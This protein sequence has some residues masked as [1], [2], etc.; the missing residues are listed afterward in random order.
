M[1]SH[2]STALADDANLFRRFTGFAVAVSTPLL[3]AMLGSAIIRSIAT[4]LSA[5][6]VLSENGSAYILLYTVGNA[7]FY[8]LPILLAYTVAGHLGCNQPLAILA[9]AILVH[10][11]LTELL[12][13]KGSAFFKLPLHDTVYPG[14]VLPILLLIP[15][16]KPI[17]RLA[18][19]LSPG[20]LKGFLK[21][22][23]ILLLSIP[24][25]LW[26][27]GPL[28]DLAGSYLISGFSFLYEHIGKTA[29]PLFSLLTP[30]WV[31]FGITPATTDAGEAAPWNTALL[32]TTAALTGAM[33]AVF[34]RFRDK[35][36]RQT[37]L[38][39]GITALAGIPLP[40]LYGVAL[41]KGM[42]LL[43]V[44]VGSGAGGLCATLAG[45]PSENANG[46]PSM[47]ETAAAL[48]GKLTGHSTLSVL[49]D[50]IPAALSVGIAI[51]L[52]FGLTW[53]F[54][55]TPRAEKKS[56]A[57]PNAAVVAAFNAAT[58]AAFKE[59]FASSPH[60]ERGGEGD[61][62]PRAITFSS[63]LSGKVIPLSQM[64]DP[65]FA[66][67]VMGQGCAILP[68][69]GKIYAPCDGTVAAASDLCN[70]LTIDSSEGAQLFIHVGRNTSRLSGKYFDLCCRAGDAVKEG[71]LLLSFDPDA[72]RR[73][74]FD[75]T[76]PLL[77]I[78]AER[79]DDLSLTCDSKVS[80]GDR[81]LTL[82]PKIEGAK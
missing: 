79:Y 82:T 31:L 15:L 32:S 61:S 19:H 78:N 35:S 68:D 1:T 46:A 13:E 54:Y 17:E 59:T 3:P 41:R 53:F 21:P 18:D 67:G 73:E 44:C 75:L 27:I 28:C 26:I 56:S 25:A 81:L 5:F 66:S 43:A 2:P 40:A 16:L 29:V 69:L 64:D 23:L 34:F 80:A 57:L 47:I 33:A 74:G 37:A 70:W 20:V 38:G 9:A 77:V 12:S 58:V 71:D 63:P 30:V 4:L 45:T 39:A 48:I 8:F 76:T 50:P 65:I 51:T 60:K 55:P 62:A 10:P 6:G 22:F 52:S 7:V 36:L 11:R 49:A 42:V 24:L 14:S 72:L